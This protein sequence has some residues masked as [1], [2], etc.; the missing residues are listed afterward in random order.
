MIVYQPPELWPNILSQKLLRSRNNAAVF[1]KRLLTCPTIGN[2]I[3]LNFTPSIFQIICIDKNP[4]INLSGEWFTIGKRLWLFMFFVHWFFLRQTFNFLKRFIRQTCCEWVTQNLH[5]RQCVDTNWGSGS[6]PDPSSSS[7]F[8]PQSSGSI[9]YG[10]W[11]C[12]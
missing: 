6:G 4:V 1:D 12:L 9:R 2:N 3:L 11:P 8:P 7:S 5:E 10:A